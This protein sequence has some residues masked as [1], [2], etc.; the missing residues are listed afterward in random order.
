[1]ACGYI[2]NYNVSVE[3]RVHV[4]PFIDNKFISKFVNYELT[5]TNVALFVLKLAADC[6]I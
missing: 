3:E 1:M 4:L 5:P 6:R 2:K